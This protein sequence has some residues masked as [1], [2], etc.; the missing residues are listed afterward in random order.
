RRGV[1]TPSG[2]DSRR[3]ASTPAPVRGGDTGLAGTGAGDGRARGETARRRRVGVHHPAERSTT[4]ATTVRERR[5][6]PGAAGPVGSVAPGQ[7][8]PGRLRPTARRDAS[9]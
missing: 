8:V 7:P 2:S 9:R 4:F 3:A 6:G 5:T 1:G